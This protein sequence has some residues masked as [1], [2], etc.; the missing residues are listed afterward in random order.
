MGK[1]SSTSDGKGGVFFGAHFSPTGRKFDTS[2]SICCLQWSGGNKRALA[3][4][5][6]GNLKYNIRIK[7]LPLSLA[8]YNISSLF[9]PLTCLP[10]MQIK[11]KLLKYL[12]VDRYVAKR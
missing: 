9:D 12:G 11:R 6:C 7:D 10:S 1:K 2:A 5:T 8:S 3:L 4:L